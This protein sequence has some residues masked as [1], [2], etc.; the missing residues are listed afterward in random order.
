MG[1]LIHFPD[2]ASD[3]LHG[4]LCHV[5]ALIHKADF[6]VSCTYQLFWLP[7]LQSLRSDLCDI[8]LVM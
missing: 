6:Y 1:S 2:W 3:L 8:Q 4:I 5:G 7:N